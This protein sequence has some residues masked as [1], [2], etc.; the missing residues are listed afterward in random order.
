MQPSQFDLPSEA[1]LQGLTDELDR[2]LANL[3]DTQRK[4]MSLRGVAWSDDGLVKAEVG[5]RGQLIDVEIDPRV[6]RHPDSQALRRAIMEAVSAAI[7]EVTEQ[8]QD[9]MF[10][11]LPPE[12]AELRAQFQPDGDDPIA[13]MLR[14]DAEILGQGRSTDA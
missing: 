12:Y 8:M 11:Q 13:Q 1:A 9:I 7:Q 4:L 6:F 10:G 14:T 5:P 3:S 2:S